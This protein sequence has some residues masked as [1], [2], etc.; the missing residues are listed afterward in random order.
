MC[1]CVLCRRICTS[2]PCDRLNSRKEYRE[3]AD[4]DISLSLS[5]QFTHSRINPIP[6]GWCHTQ[7]CI[8]YSFMTSLTKLV[9]R[10]PEKYDNIPRDGLRIWWSHIYQESE[11]EVYVNRRSVLP[12]YFS[13]IS[14]CLLYYLR[15]KEC[16]SPSIPL[17]E[18]SVPVLAKEDKYS[19]CYVFLSQK[20]GFLGKVEMEAL[21]KMAGPY[22]LACV[23]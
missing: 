20:G 2:W 11:W 19:Q 5:S 17:G 18:R 12:F 8:R 10:P 4:E 3:I 21:L 7:L 14:P 16:L 23:D 6:Q 13:P 9:Y 1:A 15:H 22:T